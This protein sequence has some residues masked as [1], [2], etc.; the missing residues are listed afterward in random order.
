MTSRFLI[1]AKQYGDPVSQ[2]AKNHILDHQDHYQAVLKIL[3]DS[4]GYALRTIQEANARLRLLRNGT[5][6]VVRPWYRPWRIQT[7]YEALNTHKA[8]T[9][10]ESRAKAA[11]QFNQM[12]NQLDKDITWRDYGVKHDQHGDLS[13]I[14]EADGTV[15]G[16]PFGSAWIK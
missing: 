4:G 2:Q 3:G 13:C 15:M 11:T 12:V 1:N 6:A 5:L 16:L 9:L 14:R 7:D 8:Q 10:A